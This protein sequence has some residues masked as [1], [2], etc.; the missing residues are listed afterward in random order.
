[1]VEKSPPLLIMRKNI[2]QPFQARV[3]TMKNRSMREVRERD[4]KIFRESGFM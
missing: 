1:M 2:P 4:W 3:V